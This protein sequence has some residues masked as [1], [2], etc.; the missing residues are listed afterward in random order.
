MKVGWI[1]RE[2]SQKLL[3][4]QIFPCLVLPQA[5]HETP[6]W[7][8][9]EPCKETESRVGGLQWWWGNQLKSPLSPS[10]ADASCEWKRQ[11]RGDFTWLPLITAASCPMAH[12][13]Y[14][15]FL[16][17]STGVSGQMERLL[18]EK[19]GRERSLLLTVSVTL[20]M[21]PAHWVQKP[22]ISNLRDPLISA[23]V[24]IKKW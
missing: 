10:S 1:H 17:L 9:G 15:A 2:S 23:A 18:G 21:H 16:I 3:A 8:L 13:P 7:V 19:D 20:L 6:L 14:E 12:F 22:A 24:T 11:K 4:E 5:C